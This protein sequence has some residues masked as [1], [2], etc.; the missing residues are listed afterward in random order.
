[1]Y[2]QGYNCV[3]SWKIGTNIQ[4]VRVGKL[5]A[6]KTVKNWVGATK[7]SQVDN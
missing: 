6:G 7:S 1:M 3:Y 2:D 4:A 5:E